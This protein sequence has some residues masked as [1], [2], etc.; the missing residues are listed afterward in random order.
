MLMQMMSAG[1]MGGGVSSAISRA[2]GAGDASARG[3]ARPACHRHRR[4]GR[5]RFSLLFFL[6]GR[7]IF[8]ALGGTWRRARSRHCLCQRRRSPGAVLIWLL[9]TLASI[10][11]GTGNMRVPSLTLLGAATLQ[12]GLGGTLGLGLGPIPRFGL[13]GVASGWS[14]ASR[15]AR[16]SC[17]GSCVP[18]ARA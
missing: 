5:T 14:S 15:R 8:R 18:A 12:I 9:N 17:S 13:V 10:V 7:S 6:F 16:C 11:R 4:R 3:G 1:A 2:L